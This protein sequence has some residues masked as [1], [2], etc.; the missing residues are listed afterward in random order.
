MKFAYTA[1]DSE[2][3]LV[4]GVLSANSERRALANL[5]AKKMKVLVL[6][7]KTFASFFQHIVFGRVSDVDLLFFVKHLNIMLKAGISLFESIEMLVGQSSGKLKVRLKTV[8]A[9][10]SAGSKLS[11]SL[12]KYPK[13]FPE[14]VVELI[15]TGELSGTLEMNLAYIA[16]FIRKDIDLKKKVKSAMMYPT[17]ILVAVLGLIMAI[18]LFVLPKIIPLFGSLNVELPL[19]TQILLWFAEFFKDYGLHTAAILMGLIIFVPIF[20]NFKWVRPVSHWMYLRTPVFGKILVQVNLARFFRV[21]STLMEAGVPIDST[22][23]ICKNVMRNHSYKSAISRMKISVERGNSMA[24]SISGNPR[25]FPVLVD[26]MMVVGERTGN[27]AESLIYLGQF[28]E[29]EVDEKM[30]NLSTVLEPI[31]LIVIGSLVAFVAFSIIGPI[32]TL[33]GGIR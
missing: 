8:L 4:K 32:Y 24:R 16:G 7:K 13:D 18:G 26:N 27:L 17:L 19:S 12:K 21:F 14:L 10:V 25:L 11:D 29:E 30:K 33:S 6:K 22:L 2:E 3:K 28:Y 31:L 9:E 5:K 15:R 20:L 23:S 1:L